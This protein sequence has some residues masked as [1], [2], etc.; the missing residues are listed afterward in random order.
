MVRDTDPLEGFQPSLQTV[1]L[2]CER[3]GELGHPIGA[4]TARDLLRAVFASEAPRLDARVRDALNT[5]LETIRI[6]TQSALGVLGATAPITPAPR[7]LLPHET[8]QP[9]RAVRKTPAAEIA[10]VGRPSGGRPKPEEAPEDE[11]SSGQNQ[12]GRD[13]LDGGERRPVFRRPRGR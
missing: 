7:A 4:N 9:A 2:L 3:L 13:D 1:E 10:R 5:S 12:R 8:P 6:A 11:P